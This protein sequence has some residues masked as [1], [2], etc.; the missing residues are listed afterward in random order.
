MRGKRSKQYR[1][2]MHQYELT[3]NFRQPYQ[4]LVDA[5]LVKDSMR[6]HMDLVGGLSRTLHAEIKPMITTCCMR[7]LYAEK[8]AQNIA[9]AKSFERRLCN[10]HEL[11]DPLSTLECLSQVVDGKKHH[12]VVA[13]QDPEVRSHMRGVPGVPLIYINRSVMIMEPMAKSTSDVRLQEER[14]KA[15]QGLKMR[16]NARTENAAQPVDQQDTQS[17]EKKRKSKGPK[18]PNPLSIKKP[19]KQRTERAPPR[20]REEDQEASELTTEDAAK[21]K[22]KRK[23]SKKAEDAIAEPSED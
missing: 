7:H 11:E 1:K 8:D 5:E 3:F 13:S 12:Y 6:F 22:R 17:S 10:H 23:P 18:G 19:K 9:L 14:K 15:R 20:N 4:V 21:R 2:L 16:I